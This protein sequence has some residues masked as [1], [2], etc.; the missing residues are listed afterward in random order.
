MDPSVRFGDLNV[1]CEGYECPN[2]PNILAGSCGPEHTLATTGAPSAAGS[3]GGYHSGARTTA[4]GECLVGG[5][6]MLGLVVV[7]LVMLGRFRRHWCTGDGP[8]CDGRAR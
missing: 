8:A 3:G 4:N 6:V 7:L 5:L 2:D 1:Q